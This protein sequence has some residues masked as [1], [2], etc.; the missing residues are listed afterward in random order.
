MRLL[1]LNP[2]TIYSKKVD[3]EKP[4][5]ISLEDSLKMTYQERI[6][7]EREIQRL[8]KSNPEPPNLKRLK[9]KGVFKKAITELNV[10]LDEVDNSVIDIQHVLNIKN[11]KDLNETLC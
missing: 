11:I 2:V 4:K 9:S 6:L 8:W 5:T 7:Y 1:N 10:T 3:W